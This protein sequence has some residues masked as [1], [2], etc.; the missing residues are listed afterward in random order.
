MLEMRRIRRKIA[1]Y[2]VSVTE[3]PAGGRESCSGPSRHPRGWGSARGKN[4]PV[5]QPL[6]SLRTLFP[7]QNTQLVLRRSPLHRKSASDPPWP[8]ARFDYKPRITRNIQLMRASF[9]TSAFPRVR[10][11]SRRRWSTL[12]PVKVHSCIRTYGCHVLIA[13]WTDW[14]DIK[15]PSIFE[16]KNVGK[17]LVNRSQGLSAYPISYPPDRV[18]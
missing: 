2:S 7:S 5:L 10:K 15:A 12:S 4:C 17:T 14:Y 13:I 8:S 11:V 6:V 3:R 16:V 18:S 1:G 9:R